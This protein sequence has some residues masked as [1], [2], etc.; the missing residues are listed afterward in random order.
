LEGANTE[1]RPPFRPLARA[2]AN[3]AIVRSRITVALE[4]G[5]PGENGEHEFA[6]RGRGID[7]CAL[8]HLKP[9]PRLVRSSIT[10]IK[11]LMLR[12]FSV[13]GCFFFGLWP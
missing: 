8:Q 3:P 11:C 2:A 7:R 4:F 13:R 12:P 1:A 6:L 5:K 10:S 9:H